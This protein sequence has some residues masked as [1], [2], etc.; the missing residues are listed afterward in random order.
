VQFA[1]ALLW[2]L[3]REPFDDARM[4]R[5]LTMALD[6]E[7]LVEAYVYG[8]GALAHGPV[9]P[10]HPWFEE[11]TPVGH[12]VAEAE[13]LLDEMGWV[14][15]GDGVR[16]RGG[17]DLSFTLLTVGSAD[18]A[19]EQMI[20]A[21]FRTVG[22]HVG[23]RQLELTTFLAVAQGRERDFDALV[24]G[25][26]GDLSLGHVA[27]LFGGED[28]GSLAYSGYRSA[29][30]DDALRRVAQAESADELERAWRDAQRTLSRD[31]P[32][33]WLYH[34][35]GVQ[36]VNRRVQGF[37]LDIRG[38]LAGVVHWWIAGEEGTE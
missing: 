38:E 19:L 15:G 26:P 5:A 3:R 32:A 1:T 33:T 18:N 37:N 27:A 36:G 22:V 9:S 14:L 8:F 4:R 13:R 6:R 10:D 11:P 23:I 30:F 2:N 17:R 7:L 16:R 29:V 28:A 34:A 25:I 20:Q 12:D 24:T 35:R 31:L 21:Q